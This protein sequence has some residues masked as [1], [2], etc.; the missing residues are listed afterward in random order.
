MAVK[1]LRDH[2]DIGLAPTPVIHEGLRHPKEPDETTNDQHGQE[3]KPFLLLET[4]CSD[5]HQH[6]L[7]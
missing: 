5:V 1:V 2:R 7:L 3:Q 6:S 4:L